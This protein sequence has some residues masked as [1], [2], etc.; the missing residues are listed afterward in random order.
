MDATCATYGREQKFIVFCSG[1]LMETD[2]LEDAGIGRYILKWIFKN[3][4]EMV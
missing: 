2:H 3:Y 4:D 1:S